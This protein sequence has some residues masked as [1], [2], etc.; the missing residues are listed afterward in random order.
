MTLRER[1]QSKPKECIQ[2]S[3]LPSAS[4]LHPSRELSG[5]WQN[6][7]WNWY[8]INFIFDK[9]L[10]CWVAS[11][12]HEPS[13][14]TLTEH[15]YSQRLSSLSVT[16]YFLCH[17]SWPL[18]QIWTW[19]QDCKCQASQNDVAK[20]GL[21]TS[22]DV[23]LLISFRQFFGCFTLSFKLCRWV[24]SRLMIFYICLTVNINPHEK[25]IKLTTSISQ[26]FTTFQPVCGA[27]PINSYCS[28]LS[29]VMNIKCI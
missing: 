19:I 15:V 6:L 21:L 2:T 9:V 1:K 27:K 13:S 3:D 28:C 12:V 5:C 23:L 10:C 25:K 11:T 20:L 7:S 14:Q 29:K 26:C 22:R 17:V 8:L 4:A 24:Y 18:S 16:F